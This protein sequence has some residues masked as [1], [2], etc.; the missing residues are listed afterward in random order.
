VLQRTFA[1]IKPDA[2]ANHWENAVMDRYR[3]AG[4]RIVRIYPAKL[5]RG[6]AKKFYEEHQG[7]FFFAGLALAMSSGRSIG[8]V[9]EGED[10]VARVRAMNGATDPQN[11]EPGT[12]RRDF[13]SAGGPFNTVHG[14][15]SPESAYREMVLFQTWFG[16]MD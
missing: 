3:N 15:D 8:L 1:I 13:Q 14:S 5:S 4:L 16:R 7:R 9:L 6:R 12:I 10:A 2:V 11:A